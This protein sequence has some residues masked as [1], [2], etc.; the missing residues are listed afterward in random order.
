MERWFVLTMAV[1]LMGDV[2]KL[3]RLQRRITELERELERL[4]E[5]RRR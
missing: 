2:W 3:Q 4:R 5:D 1:M